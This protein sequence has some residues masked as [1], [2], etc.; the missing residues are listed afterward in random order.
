MHGFR[1]RK[2]PAIFMKKTI[3]KIIKGVRLS[4]IDKK[5]ERCLTVSLDSAAG[6]CQPKKCDIKLNI[7][8]GK[9]HKKKDGWKIIDLRERTADIAMDIS[10]RKLPFEDGSVSVI[11]ASHVL[12]HIYPQ[13]LEFVLREF[14]RVL[15]SP[16]G[17]L[18]IS[19]PD[20]AKA[21]SAYTRKDHSFFAQSTITPFKDNLPLGGLLAGWFYSTRIFEDPECRHGHGHVHCF[22][23]NYMAWWLRKCGFLSVWESFYRQS[24]V[25]ELR[26]D[27]FDLHKDDS[28]F[29]EALKT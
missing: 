22:D 7:G 18:R 3:K 20:I 11:F 28:L 26:E 12:E 2:I 27:G 29:M 9:G 5:S 8:G 23:K 6:F 16:G 13:K 15:K 14:Y 21:I 10:S 17:L 4:Y 25:E 1:P 19:V 24:I